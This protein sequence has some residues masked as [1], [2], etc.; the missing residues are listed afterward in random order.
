MELVHSRAKK[1]ASSEAK[2]RAYNGD[3]ELAA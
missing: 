2:E 1:E 3:I